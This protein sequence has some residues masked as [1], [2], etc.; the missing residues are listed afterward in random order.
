[1][2]S[3]H[4]G[5]SDVPRSPLRSAAAGALYVVVLSLESLAPLARR[6]VAVSLAASPSD[7]VRR[8]LSVF[9]NS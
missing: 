9:R 6:R 1:M 5:G 7:R 2:R 4:S 3:F 8:T